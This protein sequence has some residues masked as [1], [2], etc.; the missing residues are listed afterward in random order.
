[1]SVDCGISDGLDRFS[2]SIRELSVW[3]EENRVL[4]ENNKRHDFAG[5]HGAVRD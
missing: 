1:M 2:F 4:Y 5:S 3:L